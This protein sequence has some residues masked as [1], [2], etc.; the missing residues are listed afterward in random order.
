ML[1]LVPFAVCVAGLIALAVLANRVR[2]EVAPTV[3]LVD[4]FG[5]EHRVALHEARARLLDETARARRRLSGD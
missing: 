4:R 3:A 2:R 5:R 1:W